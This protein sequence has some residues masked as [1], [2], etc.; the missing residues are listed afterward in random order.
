MKTF[1]SRALLVSLA[2]FFSAGVQV[3]AQS[4]TEPSSATIPPNN[5]VD[6][7]LDTSAQGQAKAGGLDL[8]SSGASNGLLVPYGNV[9]IGTLTPATTLNVIGK[10]G[11]LAY[12]DENGN[13]CT[14]S[15]GSGPLPSY[16]DLPS[17]AVAGWCELA[18]Y[19]PGCNAFPAIAPAYCTNYG[20]TCACS[21]GFTLKQTS[22][23]TYSNPG[24]TQVSVV[25]N[26]V[27]YTCIKN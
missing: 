4:F 18:N 20:G 12:C 9:G 10:V 7:P 6:A 26:N 14:A 15:L 1:T 27:F 17:G 3:F 19:Y 21:A 22:D 24:D 25:T 11:A 2:I 23:Q 16:N 8:N 5:N 13:N